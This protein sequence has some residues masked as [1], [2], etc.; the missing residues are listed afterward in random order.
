M[1]GGAGSVVTRAA[2]PRATPHMPLV[3]VTASQQR[4]TQQCVAAARGSGCRG[5]GTLSTSSSG[6]TSS[7]DGHANAV[8]L[9]AAIASSNR[10]TATRNCKCIWNR[11]LSSRSAAFCIST[12]SRASARAGGQRPQKPTRERERGMRASFRKPGESRGG[13]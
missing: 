13:R 7:T 2:R 5:G 12:N 9:A 3:A 1:Y 11:A 6:V 4:V 8:C 10:R